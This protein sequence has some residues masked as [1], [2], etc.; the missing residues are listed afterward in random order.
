MRWKWRLGLPLTGAV[1]IP[2][3]LWIAAIMGEPAEIVLYVAGILTASLVATL[4]VRPLLFGIMSAWLGGL[5]GVAW[6][7]LRYLPPM[8]ALGLGA[9]LSTLV[10]AIGAPLYFRTIG[11]VLRRHA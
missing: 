9:T 3:L 1:E 7:F 2:L 11:F 8:V 6:Y 4:A 5:G 10:C